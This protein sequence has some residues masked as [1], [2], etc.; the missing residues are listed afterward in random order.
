[1][2]QAQPAPFIGPPSYASITRRFSSDPNPLTFFEE[3]KAKEAIARGE[4]I[5]IHDAEV[6]GA[7]DFDV[8]ITD[9]TD[10]LLRSEI[11]ELAGIKYLEKATEADSKEKVDVGC[12]FLYGRKFRPIFPCVVSWKDQARWVFFI[13]DSGAPL[14]YLSSQTAEVLGI[15]RGPAP[16]T[17]AGYT[18]AAHISPAG[19]HF[20]DINILGY[21]YCCAYNVG[22]MPNSDKGTVHLVFNWDSKWEL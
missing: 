7:N 9:I 17:I 19:S 21:D 15:H 10:Q 6:V 12:G 13:V 14:T 1:M 18:H 5:D 3:K 11:A 4:F 20:A 16:V 8:L 2:Q 22:T